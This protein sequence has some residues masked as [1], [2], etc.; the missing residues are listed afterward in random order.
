MGRVK[1]RSFGEQEFL[2]NPDG[3]DAWSLFVDLCLGTIDRAARRVAPDEDL[4]RDLAADVLARFHDDWPEILRRF[5]A[6][7]RRSNFRVWLAVVARHA[8]IDVLR[9]RRG[10]EARPRA[11]ARLPRWEQRLWELTS[12]EDRP[13]TDAADRLRREG[14]WNG[15][16]D[17]LAERFSALQDELPDHV[18]NRADRGVRVDR[19]G[20]DS[21]DR[22]REATDTRGAAPERELARRRIHAAWQELLQ[23]LEPEDRSLVR[24]YFLEG[25]AADAVARMSGWASEMTR[26]EQVY[27]RAKRLVKKLRSAAEARGLGPA[28]LSALAD[29]DWGLALGPSPAAG[30]EVGPS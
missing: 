21:D 3:E 5:L 12:V 14:L 28:D 30:G 2:G 15:A 10:R 7:K 25:A 24:I 20:P 23:E 13:L 29:F 26:P 11:I 16:L 27:E 18:L 4:A 8:A 1:Q 17:D 9:A 6:S 22:A 19:P